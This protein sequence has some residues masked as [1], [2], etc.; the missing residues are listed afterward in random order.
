MLNDADLL[1]LQ[2]GPKTNRLQD[3]SEVYHE[4]T[5][6]NT[7]LVKISEAKKGMYCSLHFKKLSKIMCQSYL[8]SLGRN[9]YQTPQIAA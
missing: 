2:G 7:A 6:T 8:V 4:F 1:E 5:K 9:D 3:R